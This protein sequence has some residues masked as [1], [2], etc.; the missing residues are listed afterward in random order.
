M[1]PAKP[2]RTLVF[3]VVAAICLILL[4]SAFELPLQL[5]H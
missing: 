4:V 1:R 2:Q 5:I 3:I